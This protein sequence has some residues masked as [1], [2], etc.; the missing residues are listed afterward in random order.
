MSESEE[1]IVEIISLADLPDDPLQWPA[2]IDGAALTPT[3][4]MLADGFVRDLTDYVDSDPSFNQGDFYEQIW[5]G[6][7]WRDRMWFMPLTA[8]MR[9]IYYDKV[10]YHQAGL[11][12]PSSRWTWS[13]MSSDMAALN[14]SLPGIMD[15]KQQVVFI[16]AGLDTLFAFAYSQ[17]SDCTESTTANCGGLRTDDI[18]A[19]LEWYRS[20]ISQPG[21]LPDLTSLS[22][23]E[24]KRALLNVQAALSVDTPV[25]Y[26]NRLL[27]YP[28]GAV[29]LPGSE[30]FDGIVPLWVDGGFI[31]QESSRPLA[32]WDWLKFLSYQ[33][34]Q[35]S[36]RLVPSRPSVASSTYFWVT[37]PQSLG[38]VMRTAFPFAR[39]VS[40][41]DQ[42]LLSWDQLAAV[43]SGRQTPIEAAQTAPRL[44]WFQST[45]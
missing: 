4:V 8:G 5:Q 42:G 2:D 18:A 44:N 41:K 39:P 15:A 12:Q 22:P 45:P 28:L 6:A 17:N 20:L 29:P 16:D 3:E 7:Q 10:A 14:N 23:S 37:L 11:E 27:M 1:I 21:M 25:T 35:P 24:R 40:I 31:R 34:L 13:E 19:A 38:D 26:E 36:R 33:Y 32:V 43:V 9:L 30:R